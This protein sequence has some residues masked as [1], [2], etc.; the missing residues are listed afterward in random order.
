M[1]PMI[2]PQRVDDP[3]RPNF[4]ETEANIAMGLLRIAADADRLFELPAILS[5]GGRLGQK[6][7]SDLPVI[8]RLEFVITPH[9]ELSR[10]SQRYK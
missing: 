8:S 1:R 9:S 6:I 5:L 3:R 7:K 2:S 10:Q 4:G